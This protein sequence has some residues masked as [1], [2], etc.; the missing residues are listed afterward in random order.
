MRYSDFKNKIVMQ[1]LLILSISCSSEKI[2]IDKLEGYWKIEFIYQNGE[3]FSPKLSKSIFDHYQIQYPKGFLKKVT[4]ELDD[5][6]KISNDKISFEIEKNNDKY[7]INYKSRW[8]EWKSRINFLDSQK[9]ILEIGNRTFHY[10]RPKI[11]F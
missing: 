7:Y 1:L 3:K 8:D 6:F 11:K 5:S 4:L 10:K 9:L 2:Q